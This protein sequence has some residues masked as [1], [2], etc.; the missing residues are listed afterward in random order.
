MSDFAQNLSRNYLTFFPNETL[1]KHRECQGS[2]QQPS[3]RKPN[4]QESEGGKCSK[5][6]KV[7]GA[8][9]KKILKQNFKGSC[10][11]QSYDVTYKI[12]L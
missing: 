9:G 10:S 12:L 3:C 8:Q 1:S 5:R 6:K 7:T 2:Y 4:K 11:F